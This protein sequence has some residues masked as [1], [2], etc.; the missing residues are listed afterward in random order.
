MYISKFFKFTNFIKTGES[1]NALKI[2]PTLYKETNAPC[3]MDNFLLDEE[4]KDE[5]GNKIE[6]F[7]N[8]EHMT[9]EKNDQYKYISNDTECPPISFY[10]DKIKDYQKLKLCDFYYNSSFN[11]MI[12]TSNDLSTLNISNLNKN[13][14]Q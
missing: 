14:I 5:I 1:Y 2:V 8:I 3:L 4:V 13:I 9:S 12:S 7:E 11:T 6:S 10:N